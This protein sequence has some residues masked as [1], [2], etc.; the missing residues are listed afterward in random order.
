MFDR[1]KPLG[2]YVRAFSY[3]CDFGNDG[4]RCL[5]GLPPQGARA[6]EPALRSD[7][8]LAFAGSDRKLR[9]LSRSALLA[10]AAAER[11]VPPGADVTDWALFVASPSGHEVA[12]PFLRALEELSRNAPVAVLPSAVF[13]SGRINVMEHL[14]YSTMITAGHVATH[15]GVRGP[16]GCFVGEHASF[17]AMRKACLLLRWGRIRRA[18]VVCGESRREVA[19]AASGVRPWEMGCALSLACEGPIGSWELAL[20]DHSRTSST[21]RVFRE[22]EAINALTNV[23]WALENPDQHNAGHWFNEPSGTGPSIGYGVRPVFHAG[24]AS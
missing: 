22:F 2:A 12:V 6:T 5:R 19:L 3:V 18:I 20:D 14:K 13:T 9:H 23:I 8:V 15:A 11:C 21:P 24:R 17:F 16:N 4:D 1:H 10:V 7:P